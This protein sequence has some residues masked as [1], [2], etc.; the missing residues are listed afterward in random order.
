MWHAAHDLSATQVHH[1]PVITTYQH[2]ATNQ[3]AH[4][5]HQNGN[6]NKWNV[7]GQRSSYSLPHPGHAQSHQRWQKHDDKHTVV[8]VVPVRHLSSSTRNLAVMPPNASFVHSIQLD[9]RP[10][11]GGR[12]RPASMYDTPNNMPN[13]MPMMNYN[14]HQQSA[15]PHQNGFMPASKKDAMRQQQQQQQQQLQLQAQQKQHYASSNHN[16]HMN[17]NSNHNHNH[18]NG[19]RQ[20]PGELVSHCTQHNIQLSHIAHSKITRKTPES[21]GLLNC[22]KCA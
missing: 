16:N 8:P 22:V 1:H 4:H 15:S 17:N 18:S 6:M 13:S 14:H 7:A 12:P 10:M 2:Y 21:N 19:L 11:Y 3:N 9:G 20:S 5:H